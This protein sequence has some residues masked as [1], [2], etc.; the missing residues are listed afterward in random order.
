MIKFSTP[1]IT[2]FQ[3]QNARTSYSHQMYIHY[4]YETILQRQQ[5][6]KRIPLCSLLTGLQYTFP[7]YPQVN[8]GATLLRMPLAWAVKSQK[9]M[10]EK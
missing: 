5:E 9:R 10:Q 8:P 1:T 2:S 6:K 3:H 4:E 7:I